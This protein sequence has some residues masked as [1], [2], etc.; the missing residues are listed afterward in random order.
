MSFRFYLVFFF[1]NGATDGS[2]VIFPCLKSTL[3]YVYN[4]IDFPLEFPHSPLYHIKFCS[5]I[6]ENGNTP[7]KYTLDKHQHV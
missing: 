2:L 3:I 7:L 5:F 6:H 4:V 1:I